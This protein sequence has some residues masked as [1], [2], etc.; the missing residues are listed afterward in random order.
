[1]IPRYET[2][3]AS[4]A[5][6]LPRSDINHQVHQTAPFAAGSKR[7]DRSIEKSEAEIM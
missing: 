6:R 7:T 2:C 3:A 5:N 1:M 4:I